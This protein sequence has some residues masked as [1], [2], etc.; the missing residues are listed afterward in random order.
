MKQA[1]RASNS[2]S[3]QK[4]MSA[5]NNSSLSQGYNHLP[6]DQYPAL[7]SLNSESHQNEQNKKILNQFLKNNPSLLD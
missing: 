5:Q 7:S 1:M 3:I 4:M 2:M 6:Y